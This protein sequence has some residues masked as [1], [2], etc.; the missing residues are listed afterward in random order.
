MQR[1]WSSSYVKDKTDI[2]DL[3]LKL[4]LTL[5][6]EKQSPLFCRILSTL[7]S[8]AVFFFSFCNAYGQHF[9]SLTV[10]TAQEVAIALIWS[11]EATRIENEDAVI[12]KRTMRVIFINYH[13]IYD[14]NCLVLHTAVK[15]SMPTLASIKWLACKS[16]RF[17]LALCSF[18]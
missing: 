8:K 10:L 3:A 4:F 7:L 1:M 12:G 13:F 15:S 2:P 9:K 18:I 16:Q 6:C 14:L 11:V 17:I 5:C